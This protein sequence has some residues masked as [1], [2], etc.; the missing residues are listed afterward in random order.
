M[1]K[2]Y[3]QDCR[4][5]TP[6]HHHDFAWCLGNDPQCAWCRSWRSLLAHP[7]YQPWSDTAHL[8]SSTRWEIMRKHCINCVHTHICHGLLCISW[9]CQNDGYGHLPDSCRSWGPGS[10]CLHILRGHTT[11]FESPCP[12]FGLAARRALRQS[13]SNCPPV[14]APNLSKCNVIEH[15]HPVMK[16]V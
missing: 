2:W 6:N 8:G 4:Q 15:A 3:C 9:H 14:T 1:R 11:D 5:V 10:W 7:R 16:T 12:D 13:D